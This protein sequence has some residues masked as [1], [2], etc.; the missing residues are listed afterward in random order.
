VASGQHEEEA[1]QF[2]GE[3]HQLMRQGDLRGAAQRLVERAPSGSAW[4]ALKT[5]FREKAL[6]L[7]Q[8]KT[9][10]FIRDKQWVRGHQYAKTCR[11][12][13][14]VK[15]LLSDDELRKIEDMEHEVDV[16]E[17]RYLYAK[18]EDPR[19]RTLENIDKYLAEAPLKTM[20]RQMEDYRNY[21]K[22][23]QGKLDLELSIA[24]IEWGEDCYGDHNNNV[25][26]LVGGDTVIDTDVRSTRGQ[27]V[28]D[29]GEGNFESKLND[30][31]NINV[32]IIR[33]REGLAYT[34]GRSRDQGKGTFDGLVRDLRGHGKT[35]E[36]D[37]FGNKIILKIKESSLPREPRLLAWRES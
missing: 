10:K 16:A 11:Q 25:T 23:M 28:H 2:E 9:R 1:K 17:D 37:R 15:T 24:C 13:E 8:D 33:Y 18:V 32:Q 5:D 27:A 34:F 3:Y 7:S 4:S 14:Y 35:I 36:L 22:K 21:H 29:V 12:D 31:V 20:K 26:V 30:K 19:T 6:G